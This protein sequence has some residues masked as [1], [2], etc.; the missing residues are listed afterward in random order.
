M[1]LPDIIAQKHFSE[2]IR[3]GQE[4]IE[5]GVMQNPGVGMG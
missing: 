4:N 3:W 2:Y 1:S 5:V